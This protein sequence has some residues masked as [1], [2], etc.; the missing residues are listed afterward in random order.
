VVSGTDIS[1][2]T[3][4]A[5]SP[6]KDRA[7]FVFGGA[8]AF[9]N[10]FEVGARMPLYVQSSDGIKPLMMLSPPGATG[11]ARGNLAIDGKAR[12]WRGDAL[13]GIA[14]VGVEGALVLPTASANEFAGLAKPSGRLLA[15]ATATPGVLAERL[16]LNVNAGGVLR[17]RTAYQNLRIGS[18]LAWGAGASYRVLEPMWA[19]G[20]VF[21]ELLPS[22]KLDITGDASALSTIE[23]LIG[24][25]YQLERRA[26]LSLAIGRGLDNG[27][28]TP[29]LRGVLAFSYAPSAPELRPIRGHEAD[30]RDSD[31]D[32]IVDSHDKCPNEPEDKDG[33]QDEDGCPDLD[34]DND[35][36]P[37]AI[38]K[39][40]NDPEDKDGFQ[41]EDG[42]PD[43]DNDADGIPDKQDKCPNDPEDKDGFQDTDGCTDPDND[44]DGIPDGQD[45]CP[46][47]PETINGFQDDDG[48]PD[49]GD[50]LVMVSPDRLDL[51]ESIQFTG[52][53]LSK[54]S[55][56]ELGQI[57]ATLRAHVEVLR[58]RITVYVQ[59]S[60]SPE[61][62][63][64]LSVKRAIAVRDWLV[65][66]GLNAARLEVKGFGGTKPIVPPNQK[67]A[68]AANDRVE[69]IILER[70]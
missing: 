56:N 44:A 49:K 47:D 30:Y 46:S 21:G 39:C 24:I 5:E 43:P 61:K 36:V 12:A 31:G 38:D 16:T 70:K 68:Q 59:P 14:A 4:G 60:G 62:D 41:D 57:G 11:T 33:F 17:S 8:Y 2:K 48:C 20:E 26:S 15:L 35:G 52:A 50:S 58:L 18:G 55:F 3:T 69:L 22:G 65:Q 9:L 34:N 23:Y 37:D 64:E 27:F 1:G 25:R 19:T 53:K 66:W 28:G 10:R 42:C 7:M 40:P 67:G 63:Q 45:R 54:A 13:G 32:G 51:L 6:I 29:A